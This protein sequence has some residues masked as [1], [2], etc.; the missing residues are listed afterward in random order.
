MTLSEPLHERFALALPVTARR[1]SDLFAKELTYYAKLPRAVIEGEITDLV[2]RNYQ[3]FT[4][5][6]LESRAPTGAELSLSLAGASRRAREGVPLPEVL[7]AYNLA[8]RVGLQTLRD[9]ATPQEIDQV[10]NAS[11]QAQRY[12]QVLLS[13]VTAAYLNEQKAL[14][15]PAIEGR[16]ALFEALT[17]GN[18]WRAALERTGMNISPAYTVLDLHTSVAASG[19]AAAQIRTRQI[20][21][22][23]NSHAQEPVLC[24]LDFDGSGGIAL[25]PAIGCERSLLDSLTE[26]TQCPITIGLSEPAAPDDVAAA[27]TLARELA[28][29][30]IRL[31]RPAGVYRL[32]DLLAEYQLTRPGP[33]RDLLAA[34]IEPLKE[35]PRLLETLVAYLLHE[36]SRARAARALHIHTSTLDYRLHRVAKLTGLN[37]A[38][39]SSAHKLTAA[40]LAA[41]TS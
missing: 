22:A 30:A 7:A 20:Q 4:H 23:L 10:L 32:S 28:T 31:K 26:I 35:H 11:L 3:N 34:T 13:S 39:P 1:A 15:N 38:V 21:N 37:P 8:A 41:Q 24:R 5:V 6:L 33:A 18:P 12:L 27:T 17:S 25:L 36:H 19:M 40:L 14:S 16:H 29:L 9:M 2:A